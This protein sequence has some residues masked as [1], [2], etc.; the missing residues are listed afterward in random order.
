MTI[1]LTRTDL[2]DYETA[3]LHS[4]DQKVAEHSLAVGAFVTRYGRPEVLNEAASVFLE[5]LES[6]TADANIRTGALEYGMFM[7]E[8]GSNDRHASQA[9]QL[10]ERFIFDLYRATIAERQT[11]K[12]GA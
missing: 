8:F 12:V 9:Y 5:L 1:E 11:E 7:A 10:R 3:Q 2:T 4:V 6:L